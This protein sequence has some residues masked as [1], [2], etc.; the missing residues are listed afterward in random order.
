[1]ISMNTDDKELRSKIDD[2]NDLLGKELSEKERIIL[3]NDKRKLLEDLGEFEEEDDLADVVIERTKQLIDTDALS[4]EDKIYYDKILRQ[5]YIV[6]GRS[7][8]DEFWIALEYD[9]EPKNMFYLPRRKKFIDNGIMQGHQDIIDGKLDLLTISM[10]KRLGKTT[11]GIGL[12]AFLAG[13][14]IRKGVLAT[15]AGATLVNS[16]YKGAMEIM[17]SPEYNYLEIFPEA[18]V[19]ATSAEYMSVDL[20]VQKRFPSFTCRSIDGAIV[21]NTEASSLLYL[22]DCVEGFEEARN[23][24]RLEKKWQTI[25]GDVLGRRLEGCPIVICGTRYSVQDPIG[26]LQ[27]LGKKIGWRM[28]CIEIPALDENDESNWE[29]EDGKGFSTEYYRR[30]RQ[31]VSKETWESE[32]QQQPFEAKGLLFNEEKLNWYDNLPDITPDAIL[33]V[34]DVA[35]KGTDYLSA[36]VGYLIGDD[37]YIDDVVYNDAPPEI[38]KPELAK[39]LLKHRPNITRIEANNGGQEFGVNVKESYLDKYEP[40][41]RLTLQF[42][43]TTSNKETKIFVAS[44]SIIRHFWFRRDLANK[45]GTEYYQFMKNITTYT[46]QG[47]NKSDDGPDSLSMLENLITEINKPRGQV[48][49]GKFRDIGF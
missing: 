27:E 42:K 25:T 16:F 18:R 24:D 41:N 11:L 5:N 40:N 7:H 34:V 39:F 10:S 49:F 9:R 28:K 14:Y 37:V 30:E 12:I 29:Y 2:I 32:F 3:L 46:H 48:R 45:V 44:D 26:R 35:G 47:K 13:K 36:P 21:G 33:C 19:V 43:T 4:D 22:D 17:T 6:R 20:G 38:T 31:V 8:I 1:M 15:G 23:Y